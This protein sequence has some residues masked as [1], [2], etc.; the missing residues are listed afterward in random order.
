M[1]SGI[2][3]NVAAVKS[4][5]AEKTTMPKVLG[6]APGVIAKVAEKNPLKGK[7]GDV[8]TKALKNSD[9]SISKKKVGLLA[10]GAV[11]CIG[12][13]KG[14]KAKAQEKAQMKEDVPQRMM[15]EP[16]KMEMPEILPPEKP[17]SS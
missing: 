16:P 14:K 10:A 11:A 15:A 13:L 2:N 3:A 17:P 1:I 6:K 5:V 8:L 12:L 4:K 7:V 9:G